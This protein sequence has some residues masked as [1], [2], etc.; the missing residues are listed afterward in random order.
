M[1]DL[2]PGK[3]GIPMSGARRRAFNR[4]N[5]LVYSGG[6]RLVAIDRCFCGGRDFK[7]L[8][9]FD[10][11]G[12]PFGTQICA[13]CG[14]V[15]LDRMLSEADWGSFYNDIYWPLVAG[16][17]SSAYET[18]QE[19]FSDFKSF[20]KPH[21]G[22]RMKVVMEVGCGSGVRLELAGSLLEP[23]GVE[24]IGCDYSEGALRLAKA[25]GVE[26]LRG[27]IEAL[28]GGKKADLLILSHVFEHLPDMGGALKD[29]SALT[30]QDSAVYVEVPGIVDLENKREYGFDYQDYCVLAHIHNFSLT[31]LSKVFRSAGFHLV[32]GN[33]YVRAV[34]R[35]RAG[36]GSQELDPRPYEQ[37]MAALDRA[38]QRA[39]RH[40]NSV[41][42]RIRR[43]V[44]AAK[45]EIFRDNDEL[46]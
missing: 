36:E 17:D 26:T 30:H 5:E 40:D 20:I 42:R 1:H 39:V 21:L 7:P 34:F 41:I 28:K 37:I 22:G 29:I 32:Q 12:L 3:P 35:C 9:R 14:L 15:T 4:L 33:E 10:R 45:D 6:Y 16:S 44:S 19:D 2:G 43:A 46:L 31:T 23:G 38:R 25:R 8:S 24:L 18:K 13:D 27:G 11:F